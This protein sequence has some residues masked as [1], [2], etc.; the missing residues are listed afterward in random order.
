MN[1]TNLYKFQN[2]LKAL[3]EYIESCRYLAPEISFIGSKNKLN[4]GLIG[5]IKC[6]FAVGDVVQRIKKN[7]FTSIKLVDCN[8]FDVCLLPTGYSLICNTDHYNVLLFDKN[9]ELK[10]TIGTIG[11]QTIGVISACSN[12]VDAVYLSNYSFHTIIKTDLNLNTQLASFGTYNQVG[13]D[14][15][16]LNGPNG[17]CFYNNSIYVCDSRNNRIVKLNEDLKYQQ[18]FKFEYKPWHIKVLNDVA[19]VRMS[20]ANIICFYDLKTLTE[21]KRYEHNG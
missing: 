8:P 9:N 14:N 10:R 11:N 3:N 2:K 18:S 7:K 12:D 4:E 19:C 13:K 16:H 21:L 15:A 20:C 1:E 17:I 6:S 5:D